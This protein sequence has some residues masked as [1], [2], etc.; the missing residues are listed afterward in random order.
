[1]KKKYQIALVVIGCL[2]ALIGLSYAYFMVN[3][4]TVGNTGSANIKT[5][6]IEDVGFNIE[7][8]LEFN[9]LDIYPGHKNIS[10][11]KVTAFGNN[12]TI[13]YKLVWE[14]INTLNTPLKYYVYKAS[15]N[16]EATITCQKQ[17]EQIGTTKKYYET[18]TNN[19]FDNLGEI[20]ETGE[21]TKTEEKKE[22]VLKTN[23]IVKGTEEGRVI[24]Y[25]IVLEYPNL[26]ESQNIDMGGKFE[27]LVT[28][29]KE[30]DV[31]SDIT[32]KKIYQQTENGYEEINR[33]PDSNYI[34]NEEKSTC[35]NNAT[36]TIKNNKLLI[37]NLTTSGTECNLYFDEFIDTEK[38]VITNLITS[39]TEN[40]ISVKVEGTDNVGITEYYYAIDSD[41][42][43]KEES[44]TKIFTG[45]GTG[46]THTIKVYIKDEEGNQ[47]DITTK[48]V[49]TYSLAETT[50][51]KL[52]V[53]N[54]NTDIPDFSKT[55]QAS[56]SDSNTC[57]TTNGIYKNQKKDDWYGGYTYYWRGSVIN[58][59]IILA[60]YCWRIIQVNGD[61]S[62]RMIYNGNV[63][64][65]N[66]CLGNGASSVK[67]LANT[68]AYN[69]IKDHSYYVGWMYEVDKQHPNTSV[70]ANGITIGGTSSAI[71]EA[72][73]SW[74]TTNISNK[75][76]DSKVAVGKYRNDTNTTSGNTWVS[77]GS[78]FYYAPYTR[79]ITNK[80]PNIL[81]GGIYNLKVGLI[82]A[83]EIAYAGGVYNLENTSYYLYSGD[84]YW[85][86]SPAGWISG[87]AHAFAMQTAGELRHVSLKNTGGVRPVINLVNSVT[88]NSTADGTALNPF[89][90]QN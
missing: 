43:V 64:S 23:E 7:G 60:N 62:I 14:G 81:E 59:H 20:V 66:T 84:W 19:N 48:T 76:F 73:E 40:S 89:I 63:Q 74:Y 3:S 54:V 8:L 57:E 15:T 71:K 79:L 28:V 45:L 90:V 55:A 5:V 13:N 33:M 85:T 88:F 11:I 82:T 83:D 25:Y 58:N 34:I 70:N 16:E 86:M 53:T 6:T 51:S 68:S 31:T 27:G 87:S 4:N 50:L 17:I 9:D 10:K 61:G 41:D 49:T 36:P 12:D 65:G 47:S 44:D 46:T 78:T 21:I 26:E 56:C 1:M 35:T 80:K 67:Q 2:I 30:E 52:K 77:Q 32:I 42:F 75:G 69:P 24:Y 37:T 18:C 39:L 72:V 29:K 38:P 22:F